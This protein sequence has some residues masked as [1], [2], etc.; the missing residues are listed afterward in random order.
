MIRPP[1]K[2]SSS[3]GKYEIE[4]ATRYPA[5]MEV[6]EMA[7]F[8]SQKAKPPTRAKMITLFQIPFGPVIFVS[9]IEVFLFIRRGL[10]E[11]EFTLFP[12]CTL[13]MRVNQPQRKVFFDP[14]H[15]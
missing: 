8:A 1:I 4:W 9:P 11:F 15:P 12:F 7:K 2:A 3:I 14:G 10:P 13:W 5:A 6:R